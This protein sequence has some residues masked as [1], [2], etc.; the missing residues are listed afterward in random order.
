MKVLLF[1]KSEKGVNSVYVDWL[2]P[3]MKHKTN[4]RTAVDLKERIT[5]AKKVMYEVTS[6][7]LKSV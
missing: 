1:L 3:E 2:N 5:N 4:T 7:S 6:D